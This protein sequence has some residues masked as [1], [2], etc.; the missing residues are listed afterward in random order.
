LERKHKGKRLAFSGAGLLSALRAGCFGAAGLGA[1]ASF[2]AACA[3]AGAALCF[4]VSFARAASP[5]TFANSGWCAQVWN[6]RVTLGKGP[7]NASSN[8]CAGTSQSGTS[9]AISAVAA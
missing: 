9:F 8:S 3:L 7:R 2:G 1:A 5:M 6:Q 4:R